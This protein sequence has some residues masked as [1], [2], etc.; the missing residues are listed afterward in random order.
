MFAAIRPDSWNFPLLVHVLSAAL[1]VA[2][3]ALVAVALLAAI[4]S[5]EPRATATLTRFSF[6]GLLVGAIP[7]YIALRAS[8]EWI[9]SEENVEDPAWIGIGYAVADGGLLFLL[10]ATLAAGR[11]ARALREQPGPLGVGGLLAAGFTLFVLA[12]SLV[13]LWAMTAKP[14]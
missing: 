4:R 2:L 13:A 6:R 11:A 12:A 5:T 14:T 7:A 3:L 9:A 10:I 1:F 8:S